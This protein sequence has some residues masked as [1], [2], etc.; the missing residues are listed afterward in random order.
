MTDINIGILQEL[1]VLLILFL[2]YYRF[3]L[4]ER[5]NTSKRI[6]SYID[7]ISLVISSRS[8]EKNY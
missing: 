3:L 8:I 6:L 5:S 4:L 7:N 2:I 1:P